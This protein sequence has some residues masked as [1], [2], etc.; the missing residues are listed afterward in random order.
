MDQSWG[1]A[2]G[3]CLSHLKFGRMANIVPRHVNHLDQVVRGHLGAVGTAPGQIE[4]LWGGSAL[5]FLDNN[6]TT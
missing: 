2:Q 6:M 4:S 5:P 1:Q 3:V